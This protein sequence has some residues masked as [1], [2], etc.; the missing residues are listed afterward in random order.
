MKQCILFFLCFLLLFLTACAVE[1][2]PENL[3]S[4]TTIPETTETTVPAV[5]DPAETISTT[6]TISVV[7]PTE[8][9]PIPQILEP[10]VLLTGEEKTMLLKIGMAERGSTNCPECI[11]LVMCTVLN[12]VQCGWFSSIRSAIFSPDQFSPVADGSYASIK[13]NLLCYDA[14]EMIIHGGDESQGALYYEWCQGESWHSQNRH[15]L[16]QHCDIRFYD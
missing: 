4:E 12:R 10:V 15:L 1:P 16:F 2:G 9:E 7:L 8:P 11:A 13:P 3:V 5:T 14:L 6:A